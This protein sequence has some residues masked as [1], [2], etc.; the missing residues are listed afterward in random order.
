MVSPERVA[1]AILRVLDRPRARQQVGLANDL[2][3]VGF[4]FLPGVY[5][6]LVGPLF[7][8]AALDRTTSVAPGPG[9]VLASEPDGN[10]L[11]GSQPGPLVAI[12]RN[13]ATLVRGRRRP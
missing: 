5:D 1:G 7:G 13:L 12:G 8:V 3:R 4:T 2:M 9:N 10:S 11:R 6:A